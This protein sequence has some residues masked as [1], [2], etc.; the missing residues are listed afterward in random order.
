[1]THAQERIVQE[2]LRRIANGFK[3]RPS[4]S[5]GKLNHDDMTLIAREACDALGWHYYAG[6]IAREAAE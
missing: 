2:A 3:K 1:M 5:T 6:T 4:G